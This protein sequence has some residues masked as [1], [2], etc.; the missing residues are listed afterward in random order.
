MKVKDILAR[1][2]RQKQFEDYA[3]I[4]EL[5]TEMNLYGDYYKDQDR[6]TVYFIGGWHCTDSSVGYRAYF[7]DDEPV[8]ISTQV[9]RKCGE[10]IEWVSKEAYTKVRDYIGTLLEEN[11]PGPTL[12]NDEDDIGSTYKIEYN[13]Q[14]YSYHLKIPIYK[15]ETVEII[16]KHKGREINEAGQY[17]PSLVK[18]KSNRSHGLELWVELKELDFPYNLVPEIIQELSPR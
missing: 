6:L 14:L 9:G 11:I 5:A 10:D 2:D 17:E 12:I 4:T 1:V 3:N 13:E 7:L 18:I 8:A 16:E 15:G